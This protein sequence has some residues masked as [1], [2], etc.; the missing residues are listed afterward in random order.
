MTWGV[1]FAKMEEKVKKNLYVKYDFTGDDIT[2]AAN[3]A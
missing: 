1:Y 3:K 2:E